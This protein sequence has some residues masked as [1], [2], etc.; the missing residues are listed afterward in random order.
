MLVLFYKENRLNRYYGDGEEEKT[1]YQ[2]VGRF[3]RRSAEASSSGR[4]STSLPDDFRFPIDGLI[5]CITTSTDA[6]TNE[7]GL[8]PHAEGVNFIYF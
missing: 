5:Y 8:P 7:R 4:G 3:A 1:L 2:F 6:Y